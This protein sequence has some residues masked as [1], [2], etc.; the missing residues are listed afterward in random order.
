MTFHSFCTHWLLQPLLTKP[1]LYSRHH[2]TY[3]KLPQ[4]GALCILGCLCIGLPFCTEDLFLIH[5]SSILSPV[6]TEI[7]VETANTKSKCGGVTNGPRHWGPAD[8]CLYRHA[9]G[10][11]VSPRCSRVSSVVFRL[12]AL[13]FPFL[14]S[15]VY[16]LSEDWGGRLNR[17]NDPIDAISWQY[18]IFRMVL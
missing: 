10:Q 17:V 13:I 6:V 9:Q 8:F 14:F 12:A 18:C 5:F 11:V 16:C 7:K 15:V 3:P 2:A 4:N 1:I